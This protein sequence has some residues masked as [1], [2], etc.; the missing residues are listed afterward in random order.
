MTVRTRR[1]RRMGVLLIAA[2]LLAFASAPSAFGA[3]RLY[4][5]NGGND[6]ISYANLDGSGGG[7][8]LN[9]SG[10][11]PSS[12]RGVA[13]DAAGGRI[14]WANQG[15]NT[16]SYANLDGSGGGGQLDISGTT[17]SKP[18]GL[19][20]DPAAGRI[21]WANDNNTISYANL[22]GS[23]GGQLDISGANPDSPYGAAIDPAGGK[24]YWA[25]RT[26]NTISFANLDGSGGGGELNISGTTPVDP[27]GVV[28]DQASGKIYW[29]NA[30][31]TGFTIGFA[32]LDG[33][34]GGLLNTAGGVEFGAVGLG[35]DPTTGRIY[36]GNLGNNTIS[37][38]NVD[39]SGNG[40]LFNVSGA[41]PSEPRFVALLRAPSGVGAPQIAGG[42]TA[43]SVLTCSQVAWAPDVLGSFFYRAYRAP[44]SIA[45]R[46]SRNGADIAGATDTSYT[47][48]V[49]GDYRCRQTATNDAGPTSQTSDPHTISGPPDTKLTQ[50]KMNSSKH[51]VRFT[52]QATGEASG[53]QCK[54]ERPHKPALIDECA[55]PQ[56][57]KH[58]QSGRYVFA[59][60]AFG[61]AGPDPTSAEKRFTI[62]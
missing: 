36:W 49:Q 58:L 5:G 17:P 52:F 18:H 11:T 61:P 41:T 25:N 31:F 48:F 22:D 30:D 28:I 29:A 50:A 15:N 2:G 13:I 44:R 42:T 57:Y 23:G 33:S 53:F 56:I 32:N 6:T 7:G 24:I 26:T 35:I 37:Y 34:G 43:G 12:P 8:Q 21:Y 19:A 62:Q 39:G 16:I 51:K 38:A 1:G 27:H 9:L 46:W 14:Y 59:V 4:W 60:S 20:I 54:L 3:D 45:Y 10:A 55:S 40:G 47:A